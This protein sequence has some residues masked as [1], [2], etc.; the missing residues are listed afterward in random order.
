MLVDICS[1]CFFPLGSD[2]PQWVPG[3][4]C[5]LVTSPL[6]GDLPWCTCPCSRHGDA[7][8]LLDPL[9]PF[10]SL[11][12]SGLSW[13]AG[14]AC[15]CLWLLHTSSGLLR[16][17]GQ[18]SAWA[19]LRKPGFPVSAPLRWG[20]R[21]LCLDARLRNSKTYPVLA[22]WKMYMNCREFRDQSS[23]I[24]FLVGMAFLKTIRCTMSL[25]P[26][27]RSF[28]AGLLYTHPWGKGCTSLP[29]FFLGVSSSLCS[30]DSKISRI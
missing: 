1:K 3:G 7:E 27:A 21:P 8:H 13:A 24:T 18:N 28:K 26:V 5:F 17:A 22:C 2:A 9:T 4:T 30:K 19:V 12:C 29:A 15:A 6:P 11:P 23:V 16:R 14:A 20:V 10:P 25:A